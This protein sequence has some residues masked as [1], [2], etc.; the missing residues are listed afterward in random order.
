[1]EWPNLT[2]GGNYITL[3]QTTINDA[4][5]G[6]AKMFKNQTTG[7][8]VD[9]IRYNSALKRLEYWTGSAWAALDMA[10]TTAYQKPFRGAL[11]YNCPG[12]TGSGIITWA[13]ELYDTEN[14][15]SAVTNT[16]R[17]TVPVGSTKVR[18]YG[19]VMSDSDVN[20]SGEI[21]KNGSFFPGAPKWFLPTTTAAT[22]SF[23]LNSPPLTVIPGDYFEMYS[24]YGYT[25]DGAGYNAWF[26][27][28]IIE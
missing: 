12:L 16:G 23:E 13:S 6:C 10:G 9:Q 1:M 17:L 26:A 14:I 4:I 18:I 3:L 20:H 22:I 21:L 28:E 8:F 7:D 11:V 25:A 5:N 27:M 19:Q 15:H 2:I 24:V